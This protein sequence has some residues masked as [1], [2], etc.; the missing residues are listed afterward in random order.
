[1][2]C[3]NESFVTTN[4]A[5]IALQ[6][7]FDTERDGEV[8]FFEAALRITRTSDPQFH[9]RLIA[10]AEEQEVEGVATVGVM[11]SGIFFRIAAV[12]EPDGL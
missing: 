12:S 9:V 6:P 4:D 7:I 11:A 8:G 2:N 10:L 5:T 1:M 3:I